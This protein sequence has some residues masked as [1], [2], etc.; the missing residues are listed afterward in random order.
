[1][2][3]KPGTQLSESQVI[4]IAHQAYKSELTVTAIYKK[5]A[6]KF[7]DD[8]ISQK[9]E[10]FAQTEQFH[11][12]FWT[13]F[14]TRRS[15]N[16]HDVKVNTYQVHILT[17]IYG[18]LG[19]GLTLKLL[20]AGERKVIQSYA[21]IFQL[22]SITSQ[23]RTGIKH[24]LLAEIAH[25]EGF[26]KYE[27]NFKFFISQ[28]GTIFTQTSSGL[29]TIL[30]AAIGISGVYSDPFLIGVTG[31][32]VGLTG[33]LNTVVGFYF[34][35]RASQRIN[36]DILQRI[37]TICTC[38]PEVYLSRVK[39]YMLRRDYNEEIAELIANEAKDKKL[40]E[41]II[42]EEEYGIKGQIS[43]P[44]NSAV[45]AGLF[46]IIGTVLPLSPY[47]FG[48]SVSVS[49]LMSILITLV[50]LSIAG[51]LV[52]IAA[53]V[54]VRNK[55]F[56]L[57]SGGIVLATLTYIIGKSTSFLLTYFKMG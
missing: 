22:E 21:K 24:F 5:L 42:A 23:E 45:W 56:E 46:R 39:K 9:L 37:K 8:A 28:I 49:I 20:E 51:S 1:M 15:Q 16:P 40:I 44:I 34:F 57:V 10:E 50:L 29:V 19:I 47:F 55:I 41:R 32:I 3:Q 53:E 11:A 14:L 18:L 7:K 36:E 54:S 25:E 27:M 31:L 30:S 52:A 13:S 26:N 12:N 2:N 38:V 43:N 17:F 35:G 33:A 48:F 4:D 6:K